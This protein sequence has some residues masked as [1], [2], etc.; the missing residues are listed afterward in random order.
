MP[1]HSGLTKK[2]VLHSFSQGL[3]P[4]VQEPI[5]LLL[6][7]LL[8]GVAEGRPVQRSHLVLVVVAQH[9]Q[10]LE[11]LIFGQPTMR[12]AQQ[13]QSVSHPAIQP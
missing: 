12:D 11:E 8:G 1:P 2:H 3:V 6:D 4:E 5:G 13:A 9:V 10:D 7:P